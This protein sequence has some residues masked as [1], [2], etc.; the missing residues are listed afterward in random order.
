MDAGVK[1][2]KSEP[3]FSG[4]DSTRVEKPVTVYSYVGT[5]ADS[6]G[7]DGDF[8]VEEMTNV[9][10]GPKAEGVWP[11][12]GVSAAGLCK[13]TWIGV[14]RARMKKVR[15][16]SESRLSFLPLIRFLRAVRSFLRKAG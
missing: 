8:Y 10:Y 9:L 16:D 6:F 7:S 1:Q 4:F 12:A 13:R 2:A 3:L 5:L 15:Q 11:E 14:T